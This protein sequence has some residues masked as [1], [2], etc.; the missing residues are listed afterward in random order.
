M[1]T[2]AP[3]PTLTA[4]S[5]EEIVERPRCSKTFAQDGSSNKADNDEA[6]PDDVS[7]GLFFQDWKVVRETIENSV[8]PA[9]LEQMDKMSIFD[10]RKLSLTIGHY[11]WHLFCYPFLLFNHYAPSDLVDLKRS[12]SIF[13]S[14]YRTARPGRLK[15]KRPRRKLRWTPR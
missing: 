8:I 1:A 3:T 13:L 14:I 2:P 11:V 15:C 5:R 12:C 9:K 6:L 4:D 7:E 10:Q